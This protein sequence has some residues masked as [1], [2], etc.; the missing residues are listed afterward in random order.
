MSSSGT[1]P[2]DGAAAN[3]PGAPEAR[4]GWTPSGEYS[5]DAE[6]DRAGQDGEVAQEAGDRP[7]DLQ[8]D[9]AGRHATGA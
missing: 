6:Q 9:A 3:V 8:Q 5:H 2:I 1:D 4:A 7:S